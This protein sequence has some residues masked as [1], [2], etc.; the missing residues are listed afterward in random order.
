MVGVVADNL[1]RIRVACAQRGVSFLDLVGSAS[2]ADFDPNRS[3]I[4]VLVDFPDGVPDL[5]DAYMGLREDLT[6]ILGRNVD[7]IMERGVR[8]PL[9][10]ASLREDAVRL[11]AA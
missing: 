4:D 6:R 9:L 11:Y 8:N 3:D 10:L 1:E 2:R 5:F 7:V